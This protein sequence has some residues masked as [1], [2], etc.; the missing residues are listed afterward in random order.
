MTAGSDLPPFLIN[1]LP[2]KE[3]S[4]MTKYTVQN[5]GF[6]SQQGGAKI[7]VSDGER[8]GRLTVVRETEN[9]KGGRRT[10]VCICDC[11]K[12]KRVTLKN[13]RNGSIR[14]CGCLYKE[15]WTDNNFVHGLSWHPLYTVWLGFKGRCL[16]KNDQDYYN[17][18]GRG[19]GVCDDWLND[20]KAFYDWAIQ[21]GWKKD[22]YIDRKNNEKGYTPENI[23][24]VDSCLSARNKRIKNGHNKSGYVGVYFSEG[25]RCKKKWM[26]L[27][28]ANRK[29]YYVGRFH[30]PIE[31]AKARDA[32]ARELNM[33]HPLNFN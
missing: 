2:L 18:G 9:R 30:T 3:V 21:K 31:A 26:A 25:N 4:V 33:G 23:R 6:K 29:Q 5:N 19:I 17:Y 32:K 15:L 8:Y 24:F 27:I 20:F 13:L 11:G 10:F 7:H 28:S 12:T 14:S 16:N 22:L 1:Q